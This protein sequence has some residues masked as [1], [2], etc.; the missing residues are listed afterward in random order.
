[1]NKNLIEFFLV[2]CLIATAV[3]VVLLVINASQDPVETGAVVLFVITGVVF[4]ALA[5]VV[6]QKR[7]AADEA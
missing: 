3:S 7:V 2:F 5:Y 1:M 4:G 6:N